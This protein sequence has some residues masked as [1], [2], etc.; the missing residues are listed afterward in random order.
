MWHPLKHFIKITHHRHMV[1][2][3]CF[4]CGIGIQGLKHDLSKYS[5]TEFKIGMKYYTGTHSPNAEEIREKGYST[6][7]LHHSG[8]NKHHFEYWTFHQA[9]SDNYSYVKMPINY[10]KEM[11]CDRIAATKNYKGKEY[12]PSDVLEYLAYTNDE[13]VMHKETMALL[14]AWLERLI[15]DGEKK[16]LKY[17]KQVKSY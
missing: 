4:K 7:W 9:K 16:A 6:A 10:V 15:K 5:W 3:L 1:I 17:I 14:T 2:K 13:K 8:R 12:K 11:F